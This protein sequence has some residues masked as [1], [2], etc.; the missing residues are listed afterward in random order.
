MCLLENRAIIL[1]LHLLW[2]SYIYFIYILYIYV[3]SICVYIYTYIYTIYE[4]HCKIRFF[5]WGPICSLACRQLVRVLW[6]L[7]SSSRG[8]S[9]SELKSG[10]HYSNFSCWLLA[11][12]STT[13]VPCTVSLVALMQPCLIQYVVCKESCCGFVRQ[14]CFSAS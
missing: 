14:I 11:A 4:K 10:K 7:R 3:Y 12:W 13:Q 8:R 2:L 1:I 5:K 6:G 9:V